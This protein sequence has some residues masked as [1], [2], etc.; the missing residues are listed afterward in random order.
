MTFD[1]KHHQEISRNN[2]KLLE[3]RREGRLNAERSI[4]YREATHT[5]LIRLTVRRPPKSPQ[6]RRNDRS[7]WPTRSSLQFTSD[8]T[9]ICRRRQDAALGGFHI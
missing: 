2:C 6:N 3:K 8:R 7:K 1:N 5:V 9:V 4:M